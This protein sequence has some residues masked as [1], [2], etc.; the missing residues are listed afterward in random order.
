LRKAAADSGIDVASMDDEA[1]FGPVL[2]RLTFG[3]AIEMDLL[4]DYQVVVVG[5]DDPT[6]HQMV[7][8][9]KI[10]ETETGITSDARSL[11][12]HIGLAKAMDKYDLRRVI[13]FHSRVAWAS[14]FATELSE[15]VDWM[16]KRYRPD[17][18]II[19]SYVSGDM[20]TSL[21]NQRLASLADLEEGHRAVLANARCLSEGVDVP[22]L[23]GVAFID[24][25]KS[26]IDIVQAVGRAI[27]LSPEK[28]KGTI[29][30]PVFISEDDDPNV[31][32]GS[33]E[34]DK[35][36]KVVNALRAH[37][38][39]LGEELDG[40]R[41]QLGRRGTTERL[42][43]IVFDIPTKIDSQF[44]T[45]FD[46]RLVEATTDTWNFWFG[47]LEAYAEENGS[48][49]VPQSFK[50]SGKYTLGVWVNKQR[51]KQRNNKLSPD[52]LAKLE[53]LSGWDW[54]PKTSDWEAG[55]IY[56]K[57]YVD[58]EGNTQVNPKFKTTDGYNLGS[59][60]TFQMVNKD[61]LSK[62]RIVQLESLPGWTW[63]RYGS[64]WEKGFAYLQF[65][66]EQQGNANVPNSF[67]TAD[68]FR[69]GAWIGNLRS[70]KDTLSAERIARLESLSGWAWDGIEVLWNEG[71]QHLASY[72]EREG[73]ARVPGRFKSEDGFALG[74]WVNAQ[75]SKRDKLTEQRKKR[76]ES[77]SGWAW[78]ERAYR[79]GQGFNYLK[80]FV[81]EHGHSRVSGTF[82]AADGYYLGKWVAHQR[83]AKNKLSSD[84]SARLEALPGWTWNLL[85]FRWN[86]GFA[87]L[88]EFAKDTGNAKVPR[89]Y[90]TAGGYTL[91]TW[92]ATQI[93]KK[94][95]LSVERIARLEALPGWVW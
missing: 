14:R 68:G 76:L 10:V 37:D 62:G 8:D 23:D 18:E 55:F 5:I 41:T 4:S 71:F 82:K 48:A 26:E 75:R 2:H 70:R 9:R 24:P 27:R 60:V 83:S 84:Q 64:Q 34:F 29:I 1:V 22:A 45:A 40:L 47:L 19:C 30:I 93:R 43:K 59:W 38:D 57:T 20:S 44:A 88:E 6:Y 94:D 53:S 77:L 63:D 28:V 32:L 78:D 16:P 42:S 92:V 54:D 12:S 17:G 86:E 66:V 89:K 3:Q 81:E 52:Q 46:T 74:V 50:T 73:H 87:Y 65:L 51:Q 36:W 13:T 49:R 67:R 95:K 15:V 72:V 56:L 39:S 21:R 31:V 61:K 69:L 35:V 25:R 79:W 33:S 85:E 58:Q 7:D 80:E 91:G 11:A 90:K